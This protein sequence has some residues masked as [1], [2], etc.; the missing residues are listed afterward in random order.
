LGRQRVLF[1]DFNFACLLLFFVNLS[2][3]QLKS[4]I[5]D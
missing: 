5:N 2:N 4:Q 3:L 1:Q